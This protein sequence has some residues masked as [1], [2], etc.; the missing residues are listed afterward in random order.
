MW[1]PANRICKCGKDSV[2]WKVAS[3]VYP[4]I[5]CLRDG[6]SA[7]VHFRL[8]IRGMIEPK[9]NLLRLDF[10]WQLISFS[11]CVIFGPG[12]YFYISILICLV[13]KNI[14]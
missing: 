2:F 13:L 9:K 5:V 1:T 12:L 14:E 4:P 3:A 10:E 6:D 8:R 7:G 11:G